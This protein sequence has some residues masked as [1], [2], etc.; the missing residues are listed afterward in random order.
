MK[1]KFLLIPLLIPTYLTV[2]ARAQAPAGSPPMFFKEEWRAPTD[3]EHPVSQ[4]SV[5]SANLE[6]KGMEWGA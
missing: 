4:E 5:A 1:R 6:L 2:G 3:V